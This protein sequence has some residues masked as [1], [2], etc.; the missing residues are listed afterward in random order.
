[1]SYY[2]AFLG[3]PTVQWMVQKMLH[4]R[5]IHGQHCTS[6]ISLSCSYTLALVMG[7]GA[8]VGEGV[9]VALENMQFTSLPFCPSSAT[10]VNEYR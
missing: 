8:R 2:L 9:T 10:V 4:V 6:D 1:M 7:M 3:T 5:N